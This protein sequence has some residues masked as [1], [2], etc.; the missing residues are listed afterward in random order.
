MQHYSP[1]QASPSQAYSTVYLSPVSTNSTTV[2]SLTINVMVNLAAGQNLSGFDIKLHY[3]NPQPSPVLRADTLAY[4]GN[5]FVDN[6]VSTECVPGGSDPN[7][8]GCQTSDP[9]NTEFGWVHFSALPNS[10]NPVVGPRTGLLFSVNFTVEQSVKG[11]SMIHIDTA[12]LGNQGSGTFPT[13]QYIPT[14]TEDAIFSDSGVT[15][16]YN[17]LPTDTPSIVAGHLT[18]FDASGSVDVENSSI[19]SYSWDFGD[20]TTNQTTSQ[21]IPHTYASPG[22]YTVKLTV[23]DAKG[24]SNSTERTV[25]VGAALG[26]L[27]LTV[28]SLQKVLQTGVIVELFNQ[29]SAFPFENATTSSG[30]QVAFNRLIPGVYTLAFSGQYVKNSTVTETILAGWTTQDSVGIE[31]DTPPSPSTPWYGG[32]VFLGSLAG[33]IGVFGVGLFLRQRSAKNKL[34]A[35]RANRKKK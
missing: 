14:V 22:N 32:V 10:G 15:A 11:S 26:A 25:D 27:F 6:F 19:Q 23:T 18:T 1:V 28:Y 17:Y 16:F 34:R 21:T 2:S 9:T 29:S 13:F 3:S 7:Q 4:S 20:A 35:A 31:V 33:A 12:D 30:G 5:I 24:Y 8:T